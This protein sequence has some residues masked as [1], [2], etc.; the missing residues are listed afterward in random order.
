MVTLLLLFQPNIT[1]VPCRMW[2]LEEEILSLDL[3][4]G[5]KLKI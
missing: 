5:N 3:Y 4:S 2:I 1:F